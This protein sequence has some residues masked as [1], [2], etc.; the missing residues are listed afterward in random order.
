MKNSTELYDAGLALF[1]YDVARDMQTFRFRDE[2]LRVHRGSV[3][4]HD[5]LIDECPVLVAKID[6][7]RRACEPKNGAQWPSY[8]APIFDGWLPQ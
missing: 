3:Q 7:V 5:A 8:D 2:T 4:T 6:E 1:V